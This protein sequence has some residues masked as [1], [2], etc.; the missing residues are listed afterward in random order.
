MAEAQEETKEGVI[1]EMIEGVTE[2]TGVVLVSAGM[3]VAGKIA[4]LQL[5]Q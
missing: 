5:K 2:A 4:T 3:V 1:E